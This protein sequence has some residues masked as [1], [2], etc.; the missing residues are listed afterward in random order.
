MSVPSLALVT[1]RGENFL[2]L[3]VRGRAR[4]KNGGITI[5]ALSK[6]ACKDQRGSRNDSGEAMARI[7]IKYES[8]LELC[9]PVQINIRG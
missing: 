8:G 5:D 3:I 6:T 1:V 9:I 4:F 7:Q 2:C